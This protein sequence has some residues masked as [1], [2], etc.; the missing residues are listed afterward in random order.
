[1]ETSR[2]ATAEPV[3]Q[4][5]WE[6]P[7]IQRVGT[8]LARASFF[9]FQERDRAMRN[10]PSECDWILSLGGTWSFQW[11]PD[12]WSRPI[13][14]YRR[15]FDTS[16]WALLEVPSNWQLN[17]HGVPL[18]TNKRYPFLKDPPRV[19]GTPPVEFTSYRWRNQVGSYRRTF[20]V[21]ESWSGRLTFLRF[22]GV[23]SAFN[24]W[25]NGQK[26]GFAKDSR[27]PADFDITRYLQPGE[28]LLAV[29]VF[30]YSDGSYLEDQDK[31]RLSGIFRDV[32]LWSADT[33]YLRDIEAKA[34]LDADY[35]G[36][37]FS[38]RATLRNTTSGDRS[39]QVKIELLAPGA[40]LAMHEEIVEVIVRGGEEGVAQCF[41][42]VPNVEKWSAE[43]PALYIL[44]VSLH[45]P[46]GKLLEV[47]TVRLGFRKV[48]IRARQLLVN[49]QAIY[50]KGVNRNEFLPESGYVVTRESMIRDLEL[51]KQNNINTVRTSHYPNCPLW[52]DLCD[53]YG[54]YVIGEANVEAHDMG[55]FS[56]HVLLHDP[57]WKEAIIGRHRRM[58]ER[59]KNHPCVIIWSLGNES[60]NGPHFV[61]A[62]DWIK[63][64]D[65]SRPVQFESALRA[66]NTDIYCPMYA[67]PADLESYATDPTADRP[68]ILTEYAHAMGNSV[69]NFR[70]YWDIIEKYDLLQGGCIWEWCDLA[71]FKA[72]PN[73][74][75]HYLAYGGDFG[76]SPNDGNFC[77]D[78]LVQPDRRLNPHLHEVKKVYQNVKIA[79]V[80]LDSGRIRIHNGFFFTN[81]EQFEMR[82]ELRKD[83]ES[84]CSDSLRTIDLG[85]RQSRELTIPL[86]RDWL[87]DA[88]EWVLVV[89]LVLG[90]T[91]EWASRDHEIA[92]EQF[93]IKRERELTTALGRAGQTSK[94]A[95]LLQHTGESYI[96]A[97]DDWAMSFDRRRGAL[98]S[99]VHQDRELLR[100]ALEPNTWRI[101]NDNQM[102][103]G[104]R[105]LYAPWRDAV[106][107]SRTLGISAVADKGSVLMHVRTELPHLAYYDLKYLI[108]AGGS[109]EIEVS[110]KPFSDSTPPLPRLGLITGLAGNLQRVT[111]Y[112]RGPHETHSDRKTGAKLACY[113]LTVSELHHP[114]VFPQLN[115][116]RTDVRWV[117]LTDSRNKG[118]RFTADTVLQFIAHDYT[119]ED[120]ENARHEHEITRRDFIQIQLDHQQ[121]GIGG[122]NSWGAEVHEKY[123]VKAKPYHY[124]VTIQTVG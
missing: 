56:N 80:D 6:D 14:F 116:N 46:T 120:I 78:G 35:A 2:A 45:E 10:D 113:E 81:L 106:A 86:P 44:V 50:I 124:K 119:D 68:L 88:G 26:V 52:Y 103:N 123:W 30:Q 71:I 95:P 104:Y 39:V 100:R 57:A 48:E 109:L 36:G 55:A 69:G 64:R 54:M 42:S 21:P 94:D 27:T 82:W 38:V 29:E 117:K 70:D 28:N 101:P 59:D 40:Q 20:L 11:S 12:P 34:D 121:M 93:L 9:S 115:G 19:T 49:G 76:D 98:I 91:T 41:S 75:G 108:G 118:I 53:R 17:G 87:S 24:V 90:A 47:T 60:G 23:D 99:F 89:S 105:E 111:W 96:I 122:D 85:P 102:R 107:R 18:Y 79:A 4:E 112:G 110:F 33:L 73:G 32:Y 77:C 63:E 1:M 3:S 74:S 83:G 84:V 61:S 7:E 97:G 37:L 92:W 114:Y 67:F 72:L 31:W 13:D 58:V 62:Y 8:E 16:Q 25:V 66:S 22:D 5:D 43:S 51:M 65:P 15:D